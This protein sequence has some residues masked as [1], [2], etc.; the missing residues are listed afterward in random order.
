MTVRDL[1]LRIMAT[2][3]AERIGTIVRLFDPLAYTMSLLSI[4][5]A[6][7]LAA[8]IPALRAARIDPI[9]T[10]RQD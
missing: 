8:L 3:A 9:A 4:V 2:P 7:A 6:C 5:V 1:R 10:L